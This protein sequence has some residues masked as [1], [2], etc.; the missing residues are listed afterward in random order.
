MGLPVFQAAGDHRALSLA[1]AALGHAANIRARY[2]DA[3]EA[4]DL[5]DAHAVQAGSPEQNLG[6]RSSMRL[7]GST[8]LPDLLAW[9]AEHEPEEGG[10]T[11]SAN[12]GPRLAALGRFEE[13]Q[14]NPLREPC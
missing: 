7:F 12:I 2:D 9:M 5:A 4:Y 13:A 1:Y 14:G 10:I 8:P 6:W 3:A 11:G